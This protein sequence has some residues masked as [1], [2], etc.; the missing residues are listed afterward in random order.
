MRCC[1]L[2]FDVLLSSEQCIAGVRRKVLVQLW[3]GIDWRAALPSSLQRPPWV[4]E[5]AAAAPRAY[6]QEPLRG[7]LRVRENNCPSFNF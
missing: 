4:A 5:R 6:V 2:Y 7:F 3:Y 1:S